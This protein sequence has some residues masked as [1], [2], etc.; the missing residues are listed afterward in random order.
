[1]YYYKVIFSKVCYVK[2]RDEDEAR[3]MAQNE[4]VI[5]MDETVENVEPS[6]RAD[7]QQALNE[8]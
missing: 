7:V 6:C 8:W 2:A 3:E 4:D 5:I 1:M